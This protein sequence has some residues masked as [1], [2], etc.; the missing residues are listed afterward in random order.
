VPATRSPGCRSRTHAGTARSAQQS[1]TARYSSTRIPATATVWPLC[2]ATGSTVVLKVRS[3]APSSRTSVLR[4]S[5][6]R[7]RHCPWVVRSRRQLEAGVHFCSGWIVSR[8][9]ASSRR[10]GGVQLAN[11]R[12]VTSGGPRLAFTSHGVSRAWVPWLVVSGREVSELGFVAA[13]AAASASLR[14]RRARARRGAGA[15]TRRR[16]AYAAGAAGPAQWRF[17][18]SSQRA[19]R[20]DHLG[21][22][23]SATAGAECRKRIP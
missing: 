13:D 1:A 8:D 12:C 3:A 15:D 18:G 21:R 20:R 7:G 23:G 11:R 17:R 2:S 5:G 10:V 22:P 4:R 19:P 9:L 16:R 6:S 14:K